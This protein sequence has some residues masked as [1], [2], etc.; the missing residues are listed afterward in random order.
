M[1]NVATRLARRALW[2]AHG[3]PR[4]FRAFC[5]YGLV[6]VLVDLDHLPLYLALAVPGWPWKAPDGRFLHWPI[7]S[8]LWV[9]CF[10]VGS[11]LVGLLWDQIGASLWDGSEKEYYGN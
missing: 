3:Q 11:L 7:L 10:L 9:A 5:R 8:L 6:G 2:A 4:P 1:T